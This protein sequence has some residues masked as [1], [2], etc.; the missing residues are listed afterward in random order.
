MESHKEQ[1]GNR[2]ATFGRKGVSMKT[3]VSTTSPA[4]SNGRT[5]SKEITQ[6]ADQPPT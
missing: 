3:R 1:S 5:V 2:I 6:P 4:S